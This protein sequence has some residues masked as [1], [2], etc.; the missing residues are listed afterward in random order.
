MTCPWKYSRE[1]NLEAFRL[2]GALQNLMILDLV[3]DNPA[4]GWMEHDDP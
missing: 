1:E 3:V 2:G 4:A